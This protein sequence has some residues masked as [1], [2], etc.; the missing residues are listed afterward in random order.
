MSV[1]RWRLFGALSVGAATLAAVFA[2]VSFG[3]SSAGQPPP[4]VSATGDAWPAH[5]YDLSNSRATTNT[6][7]TAANVATLKK[8]WSFTIPGTGVFG[9]FAT[10]PIVYGGVVYF[11]DLNSNVYA[12]DQQTGALKWKHSFKSGVDRAERR[13]DRLRPALRG[14]REH[15]VRPQSGDRRRDLDAQADAVRP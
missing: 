5:N 13:L 6:Q 10:T 11:Q 12:V 2:I 15:G 3:A 8:K 7:I 4:E 1:P 14:D 9:N